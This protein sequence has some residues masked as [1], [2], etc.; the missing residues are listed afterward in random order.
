MPQHAAP[1]VIA[2]SC[3]RLNCEPTITYSV[4]RQEDSSLRRAVH[5]F[6]ENSILHLK[7][8]QALHSEAG[9]GWT[10]SRQVEAFV[11]LCINIIRS[12]YYRV[13]LWIEIVCVLH[14]GDLSGILNEL[15]G[16]FFGKELHLKLKM[17]GSISSLLGHV[18]CHHL[19]RVT[20]ISE[21]F[22]YTQEIRPPHDLNT[23]YAYSMLVETAALH[24]PSCPASTM[25][26]TQ[27]C[28]CTWDQSTTPPSGQWSSQ[29]MEM[30]KRKES[31]QG[32]EFCYCDFT[33][34]RQESWFKLQKSCGNII[35]NKG[36]S[37]LLYDTSWEPKILWSCSCHC[38][39]ILRMLVSSPTVSSLDKN[40]P[41]R[42]L[43]PTTKKDT[44]ASSNHITNNN[45]DMYKSNRIR[46]SDVMCHST[47]QSDCSYM[48]CTSEQSD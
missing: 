9:R 37:I 21:Q 24:T 22:A 4:W 23:P 14:A 39:T 45:S 26:C 33:S 40:F 41:N 17:K 8:E 11:S 27:L 19:Q 31:Q 32:L 3:G 35:E 47:H 29:P 28:R 25:W 10:R 43:P 46:C 5:F 38:P 42:A 1:L 13:G 48:I 36:S 15:F 34:A 44:V 12:F 16:N 6:A 2:A 7:V 18:L 30:G 20:H